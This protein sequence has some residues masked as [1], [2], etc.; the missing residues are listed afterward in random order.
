[1]VDPWENHLALQC[2]GKHLPASDTPARERE[3]MVYS[4][5]GHAGGLPQSAYRSWGFAWWEE[6]SAA[7]AAKR[8][9]LLCHAAASSGTPLQSHTSVVTLTWGNEHSYF[10][11][12]SRNVI[13]HGS[14][15]WERDTMTVALS[16]DVS[17]TEHNQGFQSSDAPG[18]KR[19]P[20]QSWTALPEVKQEI[21]QK[22]QLAKCYRQGQFLNLCLKPTS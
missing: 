18:F 14:E 6:K 1:M 16:T 10:L 8:V 4:T 11:M 21:L 7:A 9:Y 13:K 17:A 12:L 22:C 3:L 2:H 20:G 5:S 19:S 15:S